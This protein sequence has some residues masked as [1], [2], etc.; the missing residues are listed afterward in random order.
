MPLLP[1]TLI[2]YSTFVI[3]FV[4]S[5][6]RYSRQFEEG[7]W[8]FG[9]RQLDCGVTLAISNSSSPYQIGQKVFMD[10]AKLGE[11]GVVR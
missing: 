8:N 5:A 9:P 11:A 10:Q 1:D 7:V 3:L 4:V 2:S 6:P